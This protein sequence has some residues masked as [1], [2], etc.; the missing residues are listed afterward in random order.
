MK[1]YKVNKKEAAQKEKQK[2]EN[3][4][5][6]ISKSPS[7]NIKANYLNGSSGLLLIRS[8]AIRL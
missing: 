1:S 8:E 5:D 2:K 4:L 3:A 6:I 7:K